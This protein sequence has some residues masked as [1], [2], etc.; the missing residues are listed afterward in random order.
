MIVVVHQTIGV[1][2]LVNDLYDFGNSSNER[3]EDDIVI[4]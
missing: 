1:A 3:F 2:D 4:K